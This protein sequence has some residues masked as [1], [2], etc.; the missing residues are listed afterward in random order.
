MLNIFCYDNSEVL[1]SDFL[2]LYGAQLKVMNAQIEDMNAQETVQETIQETVQETVQDTAEAVPNLTID[3]PIFRMTVGN[4][5][6]AI[7]DIAYDDAVSILRTTNAGLD[8]LA[9]MTADEIMVSEYQACCVL[10]ITVGHGEHRV[11]IA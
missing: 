6:A 8:L 1:G 10:A 11:I 4:M 2:V 7:T 5:L 9:R 3:N